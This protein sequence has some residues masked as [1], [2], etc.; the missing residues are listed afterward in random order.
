MKR[1]KEN[2]EDVAEQMGIPRKLLW[3]WVTKGTRLILL[4]TAGM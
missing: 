3:E 4:G 2:T 1:M